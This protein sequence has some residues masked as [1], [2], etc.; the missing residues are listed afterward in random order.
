VN[1]QEL[2]RV[3]IGAIGRDILFVCCVLQI[4]CVIRCIRCISAIAPSAQFGRA[5]PTAA[6]PTTAALAARLVA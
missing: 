1:T 5:Q 2:R 3:G 4:L 6:A